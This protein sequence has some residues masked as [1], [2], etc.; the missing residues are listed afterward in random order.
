MDSVDNLLILQKNPKACQV[1]KF[2]AINEAAML[3][4]IKVEST[5]Y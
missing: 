5:S 1:W 4:K 3:K 2:V